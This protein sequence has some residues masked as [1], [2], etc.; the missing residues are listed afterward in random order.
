MRH[1][2]KTPIHCGRDYRSAM[3]KRSHQDMI[4]YRSDNGRSFEEV[5]KDQE[6]HKFGGKSG[7][8]KT[9]L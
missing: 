2:G 7:R 5:C 1:R 9:L 4:V 6:D 3:W 8:K